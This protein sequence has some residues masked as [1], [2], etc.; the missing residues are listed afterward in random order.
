MRVKLLAQ[1]AN[2]TAI[3]HHSGT[4]EIR[5]PYLV[6]V[7]RLAL[8]NELGGGARVTRTAVEVPMAD[9]WQARLLE[10]LVYLAAN[11]KIAVGT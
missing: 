6:E 5:L 4:A 3:L 7:N 8:E 1:D 11:V 10:V 9:G 2:A